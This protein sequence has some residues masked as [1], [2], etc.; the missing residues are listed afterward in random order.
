M[1]ALTDKKE[2]LGCGFH[3]EEELADGLTGLLDSTPACEHNNPPTREHGN[4]P[5]YEHDNPPHLCSFA[6]VDPGLLNVHGPRVWP[7]LG[8]SS[9]GFRGLLLFPWLEMPRHPCCPGTPY[10]RCCGGGSRGEGAPCM[11]RKEGSEKCAH[12]HH[13][14]ERCK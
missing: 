13:H 4:L 1:K 14:W 3:H 2:E 6:G 11:L 12:G 10:S 8:I 7:D 9:S 5:A